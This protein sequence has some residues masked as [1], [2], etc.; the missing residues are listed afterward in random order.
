[1]TLAVRRSRVLRTL[2]HTAIAGLALVLD[3]ST[4]V[5]ADTA[6]PYVALSRAIASRV[7]NSPRGSGR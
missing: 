5:S 6:R 7:E 1:M 4:I 2:R 3:V